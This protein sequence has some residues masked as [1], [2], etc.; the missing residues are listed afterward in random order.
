MGNCQSS[1]PSEA[2]FRISARPRRPDE[3]TIY[4]D[5]AWKACIDPTKMGIRRLFARPCTYGSCAVRGHL[6]HGGGIFALAR[7]RS[8]PSTNPAASGTIWAA[9]QLDLGHVTSISGHVALNPG[10]V[11][12]ISGHA[13]SI[14]GQAAS[15]SGHV[16]SIPGQAASIPGQATSIPGHVALNPG[17][18]TSI[19][20]HVA[21]ISGHVALNPG[22]LDLCWGRLD[23]SS[24]R[25]VK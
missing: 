10:H 20:G 2:L 5:R 22:R 14:P 12:S 21:S 7:S 6:R 8:L 15:I 11:T 4:R 25:V 1:A 3:S 18:A 16:T 19:P 23:G 13:A 17:Q 24:R 9:T